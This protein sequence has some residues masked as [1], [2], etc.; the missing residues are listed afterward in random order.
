VK[1]TLFMCGH[2]KDICP[3][4][5]VSSVRF[6]VFTAASMKMA[7]FWIVV[8]C[9]LVEVYQCFRGACYFHHHGNHLV[10]G[11]I[12]GCIVL[13]QNISPHINLISS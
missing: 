10:D 7:V 11:G 8:P 4:V 3:L 2:T 13:L 9:S 6:Q 1:Y 12:G 5:Q